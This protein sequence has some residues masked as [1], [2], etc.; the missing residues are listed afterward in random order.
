MRGRVRAFGTPASAVDSGDAF[1]SALIANSLLIV[2]GQW[3]P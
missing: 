3:E 2:L 1:T